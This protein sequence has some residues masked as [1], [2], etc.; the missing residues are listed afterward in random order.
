[1]AT[2]FSG[3]GLSLMDKDDAGNTVFDYAARSGNID[4]LKLLLSKNVKYTNG[5]LLMAAQAT[6]RSTNTIDVFKYLVEELK[7]NPA[8]T[9]KAGENVLHILARK[10]NQQNIL[11]YFL[12]KKLDAT[13]TDGEGNTP[14]FYASA[15]NDLPMLQ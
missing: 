9:N 11:Q 2:Y 12:D 6:R 1:L 15:G 5:A 8:A 14:L 13:K 7:L 10:N 4:L 3:K